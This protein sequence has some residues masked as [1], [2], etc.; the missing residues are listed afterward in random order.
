MALK[1]TKSS[2]HV[3]LGRPLEY[4]P[5]EAVE[6]ATSL[7]WRKG[8]EATTLNDLLNA[9][10]ISKS[11][12]YYA[13]GSKYQLF[14]HCQERF[15]HQ[16]V[17]QMLTKLEQAS[18]GRVFIESFLH[19]MVKAAHSTEEPNSY[20]SMNVT[21]EFADQNV[22]MSRVSLTATMHMVK[23]LQNAIERGQEEGVIPV[24]KDSATLAFFLMSNI[25]GI[26]ILVQAKADPV[27]IE[28]AIAVSLASL[29]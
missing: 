17:S 19:D 3:K 13:F 6:I 16:Q 12:F 11:S 22:E 4:D 1:S 21:N 5:E 2:K 25:T 29:D 24:H 7:F 26:S 23:V 9:T 20:C 14:Q 18:T 10:R 8:Y 28:E 15:C 27:K